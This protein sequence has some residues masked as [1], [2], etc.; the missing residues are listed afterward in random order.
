M[1]AVSPMMLA[2]EALSVL[3]MPLVKSATVEKKEVEVALPKVALPETEA[4][5]GAWTAGDDLLEHLAVLYVLE[6]GQPAI[7]KTKIEGLT[8]HYGYSPEGPAVE[9]FTLHERLDREHARQAGELI[10][11]LLAEHDDVEA[12]TDGMLACAQAALRGNW[13]LL[14]GVEAVAA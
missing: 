3:T 13:E 12:Q 4:C 14:S 5:V 8:A 6:A 2:T 7:S 1:V 10:V 11:Q 9:Y